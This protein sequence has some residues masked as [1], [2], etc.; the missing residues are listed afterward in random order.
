MSKKTT[1]STRPCERPER[2]K[3]V[4]FPV[5]WELASG[6]VVTCKTVD[7]G[8]NENQTE[9]GVL[10][11]TVA[12]QVLT[13]LHSLLDQVVQVFREL[14]CESVRLEDTK[15]FVSGDGTDLWDT[16]GISEKN[17]DLRWSKTFRLINISIKKP[18]FANL[19]IWSMT[20]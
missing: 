12:L 13:H 18:F 1:I 9:L 17:T 3:D 4:L 5:G 10:I 16:L 11:L 2:G 8:F 7:S 14:W 20:S 6:L 15:N 19:Q